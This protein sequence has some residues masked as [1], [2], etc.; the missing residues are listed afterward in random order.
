MFLNRKNVANTFLLQ[1]Q[2]STK[3]LTAAFL[4][5]QRYLESSYKGHRAILSR[6]ETNLPPGG[7]SYFPPTDTETCYFLLPL[8]ITRRAR[9]QALFFSAPL[10]ISKQTLPAS[11]FITWTPQHFSL[12]VNTIQME[13]AHL[14]RFERCPSCKRDT[15]LVL[16][17][18]NMRHN[19]RD[20]KDKPSLEIH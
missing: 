6:S 10:P 16:R 13:V 15:L 14:N 3:E 17:H 2:E 1:F 8:K 4:P 11:P 5:W 12:W 19:W 9:Y 7:W 18:P 20:G